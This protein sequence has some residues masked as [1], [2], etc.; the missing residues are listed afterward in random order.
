VRRNSLDVDYE[1]KL[2]VRQINPE[3]L[4]K[5]KAF[6]NIE[7]LM[8]ITVSLLV[9]IIIGSMVASGPRLTLCNL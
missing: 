1:L 7:P 8:L 6:I 4:L 3:F 9:G 5:P 2:D